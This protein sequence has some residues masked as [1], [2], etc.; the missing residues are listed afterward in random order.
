VEKW[1]K[2]FLD[3]AEVAAEDQPPTAS[4]RSLRAED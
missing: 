2:L 1:Q 3:D 4:Q